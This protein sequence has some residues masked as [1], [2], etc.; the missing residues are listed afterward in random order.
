MSLVCGCGKYSRNGAVRIRCAAMAQLRAPGAL[1]V[2]AVVMPVTSRCG[3]ADDRV[4]VADDE[5]DGVVDN[6]GDDDDL[7]VVVVVV[8]DV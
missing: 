1:A 4:A 8:G 3:G 7:L 2:V 5:D 6:Y